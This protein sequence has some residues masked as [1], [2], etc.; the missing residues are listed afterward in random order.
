MAKAEEE[1]GIA[2]TVGAHD[3]ESLLS[4]RMNEQH[5]FQRSTAMYDIVTRSSKTLLTPSCLINGPRQLKMSSSR[6]A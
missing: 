4:E 2:G 6:P 5:L 3:Q 1:T